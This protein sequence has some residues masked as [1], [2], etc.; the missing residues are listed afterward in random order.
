MHYAQLGV[1]RSALTSAPPGVPNQPLPFLAHRVHTQRALAVPVHVHY[2]MQTCMHATAALLHQTVQHLAAHRHRGCVGPLFE[3]G[4]APSVPQHCQ[5][6]PL[7]IT[8]AY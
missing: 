2:G 7:A 5:W 3:P 4:S 1:I 8:A 6:P